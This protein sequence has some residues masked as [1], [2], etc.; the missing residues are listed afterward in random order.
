[1]Q[2]FPILNFNFEITENK[3][4][5]ESIFEGFGGASSIYLIKGLAGDVKQEENNVFI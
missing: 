3:G 1:M 5:V 4:R 2:D